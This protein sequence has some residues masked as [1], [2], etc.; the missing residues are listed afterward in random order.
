[1]LMRDGPKGFG[2][3]GGVD[4]REALEVLG[5][6]VEML[7]WG[8]GVG[9][10]R[11]GELGGFNR[12]GSIRGIERF[13]EFGRIGWSWERMGEVLELDVELS[14]WARCWNWMWS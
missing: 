12:F 5:H 2:D 8:V 13:G 9:V 4:E 7:V 1:L 10:E 6:G 14:C 11:I 3:S